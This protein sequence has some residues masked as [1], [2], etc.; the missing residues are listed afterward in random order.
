M[1][2]EYFINETSSLQKCEEGSALVCDDVEG[3]EQCQCVE[4]FQCP[5]EN[6]VCE[7]KIKDDILVEECFCLECGESERICNIEEIDG[8]QEE[9]CKCE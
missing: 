9:V 3:T 7:S 5:I 2:E 8:V 1:L 6:Q 4:E